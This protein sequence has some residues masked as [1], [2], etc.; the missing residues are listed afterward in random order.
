[1]NGISVFSARFDADTFMPCDSVAYAGL[2]A[3]RG[4]DDRFADVAGC[5]DECFEA[6]SVNAI[7]IRD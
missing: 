2:R 7:V 1:V 4:G 3:D 6:L 5:G